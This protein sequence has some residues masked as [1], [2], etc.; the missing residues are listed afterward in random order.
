MGT[1]DVVIP[2]HDEAR[3]IGPIVRR[4]RERGHTVVVVDSSS[5]DDTG[6]T[7]AAAGARVVRCPRPGKGLALRV[8]VEESRAD[9]IVFCD[10]DLTSFDPGWVDL[11]AAPLGDPEIHMVKP[12]YRRPLRLPGGDVAP[13]EGGR[14]TEILARP[15][16]AALVPQLAGIAQPLAGE[17]AARRATLLECGFPDG[18]GVEIALLLQV[19]DRHGPDAVAQ[20]DLGADRWHRSR[21]L[22]DLSRTADDVLAAALAVLDAQGRIKLSE[23]PRVELTR[24]AS[25][26]L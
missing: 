12:I 25:P 14:V 1:V 18:Y 8:G 16:L 9:T 21:P 26:G 15:L 4:L 20:V 24:P 2:A 23:P 6:E 13:G 19:A 10:A 17:Y 22:R 5:A 11:L 3:T 7:A